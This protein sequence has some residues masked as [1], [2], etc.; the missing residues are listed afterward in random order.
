MEDKSNHKRLWN[1][2]RL[3]TRKGEVKG[4]LARFARF[5]AIAEAAEIE[6]V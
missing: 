3:R 1:G 5:G 4:F 6:E 2:G